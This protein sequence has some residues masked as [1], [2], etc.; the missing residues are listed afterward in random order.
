[1]QHLF[2]ESLQ[3]VWGMLLS[4]FCDPAEPTLQVT[5][6]ERFLRHKYYFAGGSS[7]FMFHNTI[8]QVLASIDAILLAVGSESASSEPKSVAAKNSL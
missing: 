7:R 6:T 5:E 2:F 8:E 3:T 4:L 1:M